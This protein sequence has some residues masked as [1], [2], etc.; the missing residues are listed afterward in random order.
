[1]SDAIAHFGGFR[2]HDR[3]ICAHQQIG[4]KADCGLAVRL[5]NAS[6][7]PHC[8]PTA[9]SKAEQVVRWR[10]FSLVT[11]CQAT[12]ELSAGRQAAVIDDDG[13]VV[14]CIDLDIPR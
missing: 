7:L 1:M 4:R 10:A 2:E 5:E 3:C 11:Q 8:T 12:W 9:R 14:A 13:N 6:L